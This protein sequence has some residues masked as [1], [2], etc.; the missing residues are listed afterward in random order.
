M[1]TKNLLLL[2]ALMPIVWAKPANAQL[3]LTLERTLEIAYESSPNM[4]SQK[5][6][7]EN[8]LENVNLT[9]AQLKSRFSLSIEPLTYNKGRGFQQLAGGYI[10]S[11][12]LSSFGSFN[13]SQPI[14]ATDG[15]VTLSNRFGFERNL[16]RENN[17]VNSFSN[18]LQLSISQPLLKKYNAN[19]MGLKQAEL[20]LEN[21]QLQYSITKLSLE[22]NVSQS[23][24]SLYSAEQSLITAKEELENQQKSYEI[25]K[26]K[27]EAGLSAEEELWQAELNLQNARSSVNDSEVSLENSKDQ[28]KQTIGLDLDED[29]AIVTNIDVKTIDIELEDA[30]EYGLQKRMELR[31]NEITLEE[32][33]MNLLSVKDN[34]KIS[35]SLEFSVG[36]QGINE[37]INLLYDTPTDN[38]T[39]GLS[40]NLPIW[41][42]GARKSRIKIAENNL[43]SSEINYEEEKKSIEI[44]IRQSFRS[45]KNLV[46]QIEIAEK[47]L[48]NA[49]KTYDLN[50]LKYENGDLTSMDL[51]QYSDQ[52][53][54]QKHSLTTARINYKLGLLQLK[55]Q[56]LWDFENNKPVL[57]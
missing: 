31:Q 33:R 5:I 18:N 32:S 44:E 38:E 40:L 49:Q 51:K 24:Y 57:D 37:E 10:D 11:E 35:G 46:F 8:Q 4:I 27:V 50:L 1:K 26:N 2:L 29:I 55:N 39:V 41:D 16:T 34:D 7:L 9:K 13:V 42:W 14:T 25:I 56:T 17:F 54:Q 45:L 47:S 30:I 23:F 53:T 43:K 48:E 20:D 6:S 28:L 15:T 36:L 21:T 19:K 52:L 12:S 3:M 22:Y